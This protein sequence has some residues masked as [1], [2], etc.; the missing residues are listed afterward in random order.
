MRLALVFLVVL[1]SGGRTL[2]Q[3]RP[4]A[5][6]ILIDATGPNAQHERRKVPLPPEGPEREAFM[7]DFIVVSLVDNEVR[8]GARTLPAAEFYTR[9]DRPDLVARA[10]D[11]TRQRVWLMA[12]GGVVAVASVVAGSLVMA[13]A[14]NTNDPRCAVSVATQN[15]CLDSSTHAATAGTIL[16][17]AGLAIGTGLI[18][19]GASIPEMVTTPQETLRLAADYNLALARKHGATGARFQLLPSLAPGYA[20]LTARLS[21]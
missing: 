21:F 3:A 6:E 19:W 12:G 14:Q 13:S 8:I 18:T 9:L 2:A 20:R 16:L 1:G 7:R 15:A 11:R 5:G 17:V 10:E 4:G